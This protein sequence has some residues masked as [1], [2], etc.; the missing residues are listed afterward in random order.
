V[1]ERGCSRPT[2]RAFELAAS[3]IL[4]QRRPLHQPS[5]PVR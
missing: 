3:C 4:Y 2:R 1:R 5:P